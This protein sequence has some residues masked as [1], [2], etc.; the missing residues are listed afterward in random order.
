MAS[1]MRENISKVAAELFATQGINATSVDAI[2]AKADIAKVTLYKYFRTKEQ[3]IIDYLRDYDEK[4]WGSLPALSGK[5]TSRQQLN[6][7]VEALLDRIAQPEFKG[8]AYINA[9]VEFPQADSP[10]NQ[11]SVSVSQNLRSQLSK[12]AKEAGIKK[13][14]NLAQQLHLIIEGTSLSCKASGVKTAVAN[15]KAMT[16]LLIDTAK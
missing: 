8:F 13:A 15:A 5:K 4:L 16:K 10:V 12:L 1:N 6:D 11:T 3:L 14:D 9:S 7:L 2:V